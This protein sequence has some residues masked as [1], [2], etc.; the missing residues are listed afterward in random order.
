[1]L[2]RLLAKASPISAPSPTGWVCACS[3]ANP[4]VTTPLVVL[5][6][7]PRPAPARQTMP[8]DVQHR[9]RSNIAE[10]ELGADAASADPPLGAFAGDRRLSGTL[11]PTHPRLKY[12]GQILLV[13]PH[14]CPLADHLDLAN[15]PQASS[16]R[17]PALVAPVVA[18]FQSGRRN[19][20]G[21]ERLTGIP[22]DTRCCAGSR[23]TPQQTRLSAGPAATQ[24][25]RRLRDGAPPLPA[26]GPA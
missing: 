9:C 24:S 22:C 12:S 21:P 11:C 23:S 6:V 16:F 15:P 18:R 1:M 13:A 7:P 2:K 4:C 5:L 10:S 17:S 3:A 20:P 19:R 26:C 8:D 14:A 25:A